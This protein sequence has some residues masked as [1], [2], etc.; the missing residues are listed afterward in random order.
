[1]IRRAVN[2][3]VWALVSA[4]LLLAFA[5]CDK[6][7]APSVKKGLLVYVEMSSPDWGFSGVVSL[8]RPDG[9]GTPMVQDLEPVILKLTDGSFARYGQTTFSP[10]GG[11]ATGRPFRIKVEIRNEQGSLTGFLDKEVAVAKADAYLLVPKAALGTGALDVTVGADLGPTAPQD[12]RASTENGYPRLDWTASEPG[13]S[14]QFEVTY[15]IYRAPADD[16]GL[17][18]VIYGVA[19]QG[20]SFVDSWADPGKSYLYWVKPECY[21]YAGPMAGPVRWN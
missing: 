3:C 6:V 19:A 17:M 8:W 21:W 1:M 12:L 16:P 13:L 2:R 18:A 11:I 7:G 5:G 14:S 20:P 15:R 4:L 10:A 9:P